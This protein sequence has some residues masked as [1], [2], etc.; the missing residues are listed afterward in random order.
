MK[1][2]QSLGSRIR[3]WFPSTPTMPNHGKAP[4]VKRTE[5]LASP[6]Q[7]VLET[8]YQRWVGVLIGLGAGMLLIGLGGAS[9]SASAGSDIQ[10]LLSF[11]GAGTDSYFFRDQIERTAFFLMV[12]IGGALLMVLGTVG[13]RSKLLR[14]VSLNKER[15][16][17]GNFLFGLGNGLIMLSFRPLFIFLLATNDPILNHN[18]F[19]LSFFAGFLAV[20]L[21]LFIAGIIAWRRKN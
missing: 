16:M 9:L 11:Q 1:V 8:K 21:I 10:K 3:G 5:P 13:L 4:N 2:K 7:S 17:L 12:G 20:G 14:I 18:N 15:N 19:Q 6:L